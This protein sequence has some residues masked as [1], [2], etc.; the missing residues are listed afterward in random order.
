MFYFNTRTTVLTIACLLATVLAEPPAVAA[1]QPPPGSRRAEWLGKSPDWGDPKNWSAGQAPGPGD[2]ACFIVRDGEVGRQPFLAKDTAVGGLYFDNGVTARRTVGDDA[3]FTPGLKPAVIPGVKPLPE[4][5]LVGWSLQGAGRLSLGSGGI[6]FADAG[7]TVVIHPDI[8]LRAWQEWRVGRTDGS[9]RLREFLYR[10]ALVSLAA[11]RAGLQREGRTMAPRIDRWD[12]LNPLTDDCYGNEAVLS[13][14]GRLSG[15]GGIRKTGS[16]RVYYANSASPVFTGGTSVECG[17]VEWRIPEITVSGTYRFGAKPVVLDGG[18]FCFG[19]AKCGSQKDQI[20]TLATPVVVTGRN[21]ILEYSQEI[22]RTDPPASSPREARQA[23]ARIPHSRFVGPVTLRGGLKFEHNTAGAANSN[24]YI[25]GPI[26]LD[27]ASPAVLALIEGDFTTDRWDM[28]I[29]VSGRITDGPGNAGN[30]LIVRSN[31]GTAT[32]RSPENDYAGGTVVAMSGLGFID[33]PE[34]FPAWIRV[35]PQARLG[36]GDV[37]VEPGGALFLTSPANLADKAIVAVRNNRLANGVVCLGYN[38]LPRFDR[39]SAGVLLFDCDEFDSVDDLST[40][41]N[42]RMFLGAGRHARGRQPAFTGTRLKPGA[43]QVYRLG[44][45][46][47]AQRADQVYRPGAGLVAQGADDGREPTL[48]IRHGVLEG[49]AAVEVGASGYRGIGS[50]RLEGANT[51]RGPLTIRGGP[52]FGRPAETIVEGIAQSAPGAS[53]LGDPGGSVFLEGGL[54]RLR[55]AAGADQPVRKGPLA[56]SG[57]CSIELGAQRGARAALTLADLLRDRMGRGLLVLHAL[58]DKLQ[59]EERLSISSWKED[60]RLLPPHILCQQ[61]N[62]PGFACYDAKDGKGIRPFASPKPDLETA[63]PDDVVACTAGS[64]QGRRRTVKALS[65][66]GP[67]GGTGT[68]GI[69]GGGLILGG[70]ITPN[71][72]FGPTEGVIVGNGGRESRI[73]SGKISGSG[74]LTA[75]GVTLANADNDFT[76][77]VAVHGTVWAEFDTRRDDG[78]V[79][80]GSLG[81]LANPIVL[82][83]GVLLRVRGERSGNCL[84]ASRT[85]YLGACGGALNNCWECICPAVTVYGKITGPGTLF[86]PAWDGGRVVIDNPENDYTGGTLVGAHCGGMMVTPRGKLG[87]GPVLLRADDTTLHLYGDANIDARARLTVS[88][89]AIAAFR[90]ARP[91]IGSLD[92][93]GFVLLGDRDVATQLTLGGDN[94]DATFYGKIRNAC[95]SSAGSIAKT[96]KGVWTVYGAQEYGGGTTVDGGTLVLMGG[97]AGDVAVHKGA[98][99]VLKGVVAGNVRVDHGATFRNEGKVAGKVRAAGP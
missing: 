66:A 95:R 34:W 65:T 94:S 80:R 8:E 20:P 22:F 23:L 12:G 58:G 78:T 60:V 73:V 33:N 59:D 5:R 40:L 9:S 90:S 98:A 54:L 92:G 47:A 70:N 82:N 79:T 31:S 17:A 37:T 96:G 36:R 63:G 48:R 2:V 3:S 4:N 93:S 77:P 86:Q 75:R 76:G 57:C 74:G 83:G 56:F 67:L 1:G 10:E 64:L 46:L 89:Y 7:G 62:L 26:T 30:P 25:D 24:V 16:G 68:I 13:L 44:A 41:G 51:F 29:H 35:E 18:L 97:L 19:A 52:N 45:G 88:H 42:G 11:D 27:Q 84:A 99:F 39:E 14:L 15:P 87:A 91:V 38:G 72:D 21:G 69:T 53:P 81:P 49:P 61:G 85:I 6:R 28:R 55:A 50:V 71:V 43:D 32:I